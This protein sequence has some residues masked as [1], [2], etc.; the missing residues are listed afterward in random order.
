MRI[1]IAEFLGRVQRKLHP[2]AEACKRLCIGTDVT[3]STQDVLS[4]AEK[5]LNDPADEG[6]PSGRRK[7]KPGFPG[8]FW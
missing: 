2:W 7:R 1:R 3:T 6:T 8:R 4:I 5:P